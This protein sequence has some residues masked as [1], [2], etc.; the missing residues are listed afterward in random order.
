MT[1]Q[2]NTNQKEAGIDIAAVGMTISDQV[3][4]L[5]IFISMYKYDKWLINQKDV[6]NSDYTPNARVSKYMDHIDKNIRDG[7]I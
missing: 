5:G 4:S 3:I 7:Y 1:Y 6:T 2:V